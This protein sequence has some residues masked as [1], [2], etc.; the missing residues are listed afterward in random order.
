[1]HFGDGDITLVGTMNY[2][3]INFVSSKR[4]KIDICPFYVNFMLQLN[5]VMA[6]SKF[7]DAAVNL[8]LFA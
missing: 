4:A 7:V 3:G 8:R 1:M 2:L 6:H 5:A